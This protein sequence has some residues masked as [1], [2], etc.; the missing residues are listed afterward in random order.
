MFHAKSGRFILAGT[1]LESTRATIELTNH[2]SAFG[3]HAA[4]VLPP[5]YYFNMMNDEALI[6][7]YTDVA[8]HTDIPILIYNVSKYTH[9]E[10]SAQVIEVLSQHPNIIGM[11][12]S[13]GNI[14]QLLDYQKVM[15]PDFN[16]LTGSASIWYPALGNGVSAGIMAL[17][18]ILPRECVQIQKDFNAGNEQEAEALYCRLF[19][20]NRAITEIYGIAGLKYAADLLGYDGGFVRK[21]LLP[22][23]DVAK[24]KLQQILEEAGMI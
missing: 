15:A 18:N 11:K 17:A 7:F 16:L 21:P 24:Q 14:M 20:V 10:I 9:I 19:P 1:G 8:D 13:S 22:L 12:D 23:T 5:F 4:L 3:A 2:A 6:A